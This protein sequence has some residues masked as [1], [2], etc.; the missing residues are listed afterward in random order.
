MKE[1]EMRLN[2][3]ANKNTIL[4]NIKEKCYKKVRE[5]YG[6]DLP[7]NIE[8]RLKYE[9]DLIMQNNFQLKFLIA[10]YV[11]QKSKE[12]GYLTYTGGSIGNSFVAYLLEITDFD[13]IS[14][15]LP[16]ELFM[17]KNYNKQSEIVLYISDEIIDKILEDIKDVREEIKI[18]KTDVPTFLNKLQKATKIASQY[19]DLNDK[20]TLTLFATA[21][22]RGIFGLQED[23][24]INMLKQVKIKNFN[25]L[26]Y[27]YALKHGSRT[28]TQNAECLIKDLDMPLEMLVSNRADVMN[29]LIKK[30]IDEE[31]AYAITEFIKDG[32]AH[33]AND[34]FDFSNLKRECEI[35][36]KE[37]KEILNNHHIP[38]YYI[39]SC[40]KI[41]YLFPKAHAIEEVENAFRIAWY[42]AH[43]PKSFYKVYFETYKNIEIDNYY[44][45]N[46][47]QNKLKR[48]YNERLDNQKEKYKLDVIINDFEILLEMFKRGI[49][50]DKIR[51]LDD[52]DLINSKAIGDYCRNIGHKF[53]TE[54]L[55]V[56]VYRNNKMDL[57]EKIR[58]YQDL[59]DN[60]QDME[61]REEI[62]CK[63]YDSVKLMIQNEIDRVRCIY[64][65]MI[66]FEENCVYILETY[67]KHYSFFNKVIEYLNNTYKDVCTKV[68]CLIKEDNV[69]DFFTITKKYLY[70]DEEI[71]ADY[72]VI[73]QQIKLINIKRN[74]N[75]MCDIGE[76]FINLPVPFKKGD[77]LINEMMLKYLEN[78]IFVLDDLTIW[79]KKATQN[80]NIRNLGEISMT[81]MC[82]YLPENDAELSYGTLWDYDCF[83]YYDETLEGNNRILKLVSNYL[84]G[85][86]ENLELFIKTYEYLKMDFEKTKFCYYEDENLK[87]LGFTD[88]NIST[89]KSNNKED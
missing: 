77:I 28:W 67:S 40:E 65:D 39:N 59:I 52:Y 51:K 85:K 12:M 48:L 74:H 35:K 78:P 29:Y 70:N 38:K 76:L 50:K 26:V 58:K 89:M 11:V 86:I 46:E 25:D 4:N 57:E 69:I 45:I 10:S 61:V 87:L 75:D 83:E 19:I 80:S 81:G 60:Y 53:N 33:K 36:W 3:I 72:V 2:E 49:K 1:Q 73:N 63:H 27:L 44:T 82:Y 13:P 17:P 9:L 71:S 24:T 6:E 54:E 56:L 64:S 43:C 41:I 8:K 34:L 18:R 31:T 84:K 7:E 15:N 88:E 32:K 68:E 66:K 30:G 16:F 5:I 79:D 21:D 62:N 42:K 37:Y 47:V 22:T 55:A 14:Y 23:F 20:D